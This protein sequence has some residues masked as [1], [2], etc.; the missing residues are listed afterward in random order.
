MNKKQ[1]IVLWAMG[2]LICALTVF[3]PKYYVT[4]SKQRCIT[5]DDPIPGAFTRVRWYSVIQGSI[6]IVVVGALALY[7]LR[8]KKSV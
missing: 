1:M 6:I 3:A 4:C 5:W 2:I 8:D 7:S